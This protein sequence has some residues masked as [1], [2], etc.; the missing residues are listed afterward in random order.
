[1]RGMLTGLHEPRATHLAMLEALGTAA[2]TYAPPT[3]ALFAS[4]TSGTSSAISPLL[5]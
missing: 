2:A 5:P 1:M 3:R 4:A